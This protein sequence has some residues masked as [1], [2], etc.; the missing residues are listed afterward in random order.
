MWIC[1]SGRTERRPHCRSNLAHSK[2]ARQALAEPDAKLLADHS[3]KLQKL[4]PVLA[5]RQVPGCVLG[6]G[7][8]RP[9]PLGWSTWVSTAAFPRDADETILRL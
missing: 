9:Q 2:L 4:Q 8:D 5:A 7:D 1:P 3:E 6:A